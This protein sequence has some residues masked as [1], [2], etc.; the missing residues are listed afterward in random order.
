MIEFYLSEIPIWIME[1][2]ILLIIIVGIYDEFAYID[3]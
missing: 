1:N 3:R 2:F